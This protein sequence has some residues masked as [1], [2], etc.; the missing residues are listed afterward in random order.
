[1]LMPTSY[2]NVV[3][4][5]H[6]FRLNMFAERSYRSVAHKMSISGAK[7]KVLRVNKQTHTKVNV[8]VRVK[9]FFFFASK[10]Y[11]K[12]PISPPS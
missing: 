10:P 5:I 3:N 7:E 11:R 1:M 6:I 4:I 8:M 12:I 2:R 9:M